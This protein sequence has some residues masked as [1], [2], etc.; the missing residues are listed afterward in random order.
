MQISV[1]P[2]VPMRYRT[3]GATGE[4]SPAQLTDQAPVNQQ[5]GR[6]APAALLAPLLHLLDLRLQQGAGLLRDVVAQLQLE[7]AAGGDDDTGQA[8]VDGGGSGEL[9]WLASGLRGPGGLVPAPLHERHQGA[10]ADGGRGQI[11]LGAEPEPCIPVGGVAG[12]GALGA[13]VLDVGGRLVV[14]PGEPVLGR[15][16]EPCGRPGGRRARGAA[17]RD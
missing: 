11:L 1:A 15:R 17:R 3:L 12:A 2:P 10:G 8:A 5:G 4:W 16:V 14:E 6:R 9:P 7:L 13:V